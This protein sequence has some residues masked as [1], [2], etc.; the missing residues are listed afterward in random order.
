MLDLTR[1]W[2]ISLHRGNG[3]FFALGILGV[4][5]VLYQFDAPVSLWA[6]SWPQPIRDVFF[7]TTDLGK[8]DWVL[9]PALVILLLS[10]L[11]MLLL[12]DFRRQA[13]VEVAMLSGFVFAAIAV[14]GLT[15]N[16]IKRLIGRGRPEVLDVAGALDFQNVINDVAYQSFPSGHTT[17]AFAMCFALSFLLPRLLPWMLA[18]AALIG[19]SR[20]VVG[21]HY[22]TDVFGGLLV[23]TFGAYLVRNA[24][25][26][27]GWLFERREDGSIHRRALPALS[28]L[29]RQRP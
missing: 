1:P 19:L 7:A 12:K 27:R 6:Q 16:I 11:G 17:T 28:A 14:P 22:P 15:A 3:L 10:G 20:I 26:A 13:S 29:A 25:A 8:S 4:L 18:V 5:V 21:V 9:I 2:P 24:F 23:G